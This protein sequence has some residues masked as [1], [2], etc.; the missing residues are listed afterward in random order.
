[1]TSFPKH[2]LLL[3]CV[4]S[5]LHI[6]YSTKTV[7]SVRVSTHTS[8]STSTHVRFSLPNHRDM[9][10]AAYDTLDR[11]KLGLEPGTSTS[12]GT[13][14]LEAIKKSHEE[15]LKS[16]S[17]AAAA[18]SSPS[19]SSSS[20]TIFSRISQVV[21]R[22]T[23]NTAASVVNTVGDTFDTLFGRRREAQSIIE[24]SHSFQEFVQRINLRLGVTYPDMPLPGN[25]PVSMESSLRTLALKLFT[26]RHMVGTGLSGIH[27]MASSHEGDRQ[28]WHAM[29]DPGTNAELTNAGVKNAI[30]AY[31]KGLYAR[32]RM[33]EPA[34]RW[35][36]F[37]R[38]LHTVQD[39]YSDA[40]CARD[41]D[42][43]DDLPIRFFQ[44]YAHQGMSKHAESD[45]SSDELTHEVDEY[46]KNDKKLKHF[47]HS[48]MYLMR[49]SLLQQKAQAMSIE[50]LHV[51][52]RD[53][54]PSTGYG[55]GVF[56]NGQHD[57][58]KQVLYVLNR[59]FVFAD[60][61]WANALTGGTLEEYSVKPQYNRARDQNEFRI[62]QGT[63]MAMRDAAAG[64]YGSHSRPQEANRRL[65]LSVLRTASIKLMRAAVFGDFSH[66]DL[67]GGA[68][69][70]LR[71]TVGSYP[72]IQTE[73]A[74][75]DSGSKYAAMTKAAGS[76]DLSHAYNVELHD[77]ITIELYDDDKAFGVP[78]PAESDL[79]G[80]AAQSCFAIYQAGVSSADNIG[81][82]TF[83]LMDKHGKIVG[84]VELIVRISLGVHATRSTEQGL[85][86]YVPFFKEQ[87]E[88]VEQEK[89]A[90]L[91]KLAE[92]RKRGEIQ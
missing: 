19:S 8:T 26:G 11:Q 49:K 32:A 36:Y 4:V 57:N 74:M 18:A 61:K 46:Q 31:L 24:K 67:L 10:E 54:K 64:V 13:G 40:H 50:L 29:V 42:A 90:N 76:W 20:S 37:G 28:Y 53:A 14:G 70:Y 84:R 91:A 41:L 80:R 73:T 82:T 92:S 43:S 7:L 45:T 56:I 47:F 78:D 22:L 23:D 75:F 5:L 51:L 79:L 86:D 16:T 55:S 85:S 52:A 2:A 44:N 83:D 63:S 3:L 66:A 9:V 6:I 21:S 81:R 77:M 30:I 60:E 72:A 38:M 65:P 35:W 1:M 15:Y 58:W 62:F 12:T 25:E 17:A 59:V 88:L 33:S 71:I 39:S 48:T 68:E 34:K 89:K 87:K 69:L 27:Q